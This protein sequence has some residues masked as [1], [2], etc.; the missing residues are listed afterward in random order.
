M[1][2]TPNALAA[3]HRART[4]ATIARTRA[5]SPAPVPNADGRTALMDIAT[6]LDDA[7]TALETEDPGAW[8]GIVI[9]NTLPFDTSIAL[10]AAD[11]I[12]A[13]NPAIGFP[14]RFTQYVTA[15]VYGNEVD[16]PPSLLRGGP[17]LIAREGDLFARLFALHGHLRLMLPARDTTALLEGVFALHWKHALLAASAA[18]GADRP[19][20]R[21]AVPSAVEIPTPGTPMA[22]RRAHEA[23]GPTVTYGLNDRRLPCHVSDQ[24]VTHTAVRMVSHLG[25]TIAACDDHQD[26]AAI[27]ARELYGSLD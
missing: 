5:A 23:Y 14:P 12:A 7:A 26:A 17:V 10:H 11:D 16:L 22:L 13:A 21:P 2:A 3:A 24:G 8:D 9:T 20:N 15:P 27:A 18:V 1:P 6:L 4:I 25:A 19:C